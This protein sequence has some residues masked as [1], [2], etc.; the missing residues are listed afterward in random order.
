MLEFKHAVL[1]L[2]FLSVYWFIDCKVSYFQVLSKDDPPRKTYVYRLDVPVAAR[3][4]TLAV[5]PFEIF[6]DQHHGLISNMCLQSN[7]SKLHN[8]M[9]FFHN[10]FRFD[11]PNCI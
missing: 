7:L 5:A 8:T 2:L 10:A 4:I 11:N 6:P 3:W 9:E 1:I